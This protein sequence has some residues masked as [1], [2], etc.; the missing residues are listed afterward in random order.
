MNIYISKLDCLTT[1]A[2]LQELFAPYGKSVC[3]S[4]RTITDV[5]KD[6][7]DT[8]A[9]MYMENQV[10]GNA[11]IAGLNQLSVRNRQ[12]EVKEAG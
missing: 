12:I 11:A 8:F 6:Q 7:M 2:D 10:E 3:S 4:V 1:P 9:Y 5:S